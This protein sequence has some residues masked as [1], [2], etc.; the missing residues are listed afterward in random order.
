MEI[1]VADF[2]YNGKF[3]ASEKI[4]L[5]EREKSTLDLCEVWGY[6]R[7][8]IQTYVYPADITGDLVEILPGKRTYLVNGK[9]KIVEGN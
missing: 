9:N 2:F 6:R 7:E 4:R 5:V 1:C 3:L 8:K